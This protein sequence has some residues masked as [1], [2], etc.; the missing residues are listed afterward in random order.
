MKI[1]KENLAINLLVVVPC[2][3]WLVAVAAPLVFVVPLVFLVVFCGVAFP[4]LGKSV[5]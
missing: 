3:A 2:A 1:D 4:V 5:L